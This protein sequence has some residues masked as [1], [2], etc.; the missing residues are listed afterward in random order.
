MARCIS[1]QVTIIDEQLTFKT[2]LSIDILLCFQES[3]TGPHLQ[4]VET[5]QNPIR[6]LLKIHF[7]II[8]PSTLQY[9]I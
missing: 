7:N 9:H 1:V 6:Y 2:Y 4:P 8:I 3:V 5:S